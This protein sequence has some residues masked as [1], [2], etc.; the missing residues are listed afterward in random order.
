MIG[1]KDAWNDANK[2]TVQCPNGECNGREAAFYSVQIRSADEP[3]TNFF[4][5]S[6]VWGWWGDGETL[7]NE[8]RYSV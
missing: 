7:A 2:T 1:G 6:W 3:S 5:V 4:R 8:M